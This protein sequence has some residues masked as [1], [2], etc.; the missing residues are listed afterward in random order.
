M[1]IFKIG[2]T[3]KH[4]LARANGYSKGS[5]IYC[6]FPVAGN[7]ELEL[8]NQ[9]KKQFIGIGLALNNAIIMVLAAINA[10]LIGWII[11]RSRGDANFE[12]HTYQT[13]FLILLFI[14]MLAVIFSVFFIKET[15]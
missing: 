2:F 15:F 14:A 10:P 5:K 8:I 7:P 4:I 1:D 6:C 11:D 9:F 3:S 13:T 12:L